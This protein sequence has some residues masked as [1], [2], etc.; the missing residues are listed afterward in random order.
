MLSLEQGLL[1]AV[2]RDAL[3]QTESGSANATVVEAGLQAALAGIEFRPPS[4]TLVNGV[5]GRAIEFDELIET[6]CGLRCVREPAECVRRCVRTVAEKGVDVVVEIGREGSVGPMV[7]SA[8]PES[9]TATEQEAGN[10]VREPVVLP[11]PG[12]AGEE[13]SPA[14]GATGFVRA[15][16]RAYEAGLPVSFRGLYA[17]ETRRRISVPG[18]PFEPWRYWIEMPKR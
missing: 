18:Y 4:I 10:G 2:A 14:N 7:A 12:Q 11:G 9:A 5:T 17:G 16:A 13:S 1:L 6:A 15:V 3:T 8:W